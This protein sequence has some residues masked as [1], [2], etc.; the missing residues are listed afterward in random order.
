[1][2]RRSALILLGV[3][4][5][6][7]ERD[8]QLNLRDQP[9]QSAWRTEVNVLLRDANRRWAAA[10]RDFARV[11]SA[12]RKSAKIDRSTKMDSARRE[13]DM[14]GARGHP[15]RL[16]KRAKSVAGCPATALRS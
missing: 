2:G 10:S 13:A 12:E 15:K 16:R 9:C 8:K 3:S 5:A 14:A 4:A 11:A 6:W 7:T 1:M